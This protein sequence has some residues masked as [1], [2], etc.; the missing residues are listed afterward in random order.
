MSKSFHRQ[1]QREE[2]VRA[3]VLSIGPWDGKTVGTLLRL[4]W[5][6]FG[7]RQQMGYWS[8]PEA[9]T[10]VL[11][12]RGERCDSLGGAIPEENVVTLSRSDSRGGENVVTFSRGAIL[13]VIPLH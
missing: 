7:D 5:D 1:K 11:Q 3:Y 9:R 13:V 2:H 10:T 8:L 4:L 12:W 6:L